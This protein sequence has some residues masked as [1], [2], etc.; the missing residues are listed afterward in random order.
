MSGKK[1]ITIYDIASELKVSPSTVS[2]AL[3]DHFSIGKELTETIKK[4][5]HK[6]GYQ[7]NHIAA[8]LRKNK[9][10]TIGVLIPWINRPFISSLISGVEE[11]ARQNMFNVVISQSH[12]SYESEVA[13]CTTLYNSRI[14]G[15]V[16]SLAMQTKKYDHF[17]Q[18]IE[19]D[20]PVVFVDRVAEELE[21]DRVIIDNYASGFIATE[22]LIQQ[23]CQRIAHFAGAQHRQIYRERQ[24]GYIEALKQYQLPVDEQLIIQ[25]NVLSAEEGHAMTNQ[26]LDLPHPPDGLFSSND[27]AAVS[28]IQIAKKRKVKVP[29]EL[30]IIGFNNDPVSLII[31][32]PLSTIGHPAVDLGRIAAKQVLK[33]RE[34]DVVS[35]ETITL[36]TE[37]IVR[38]SSLK[39]AR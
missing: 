10:N 9:T 11:I 18:F 14:G 13:N 20:I 2:R 28:A 39:K 3:K 38:E 37:L 16:V 22:H 17:N 32:P 8:S 31:D 21:S 33:H 23:G 5:A 34:H 6:Y 1:N 26:L 35:S 30:A 36:K 12:D 4:V 27:T 29:K 19:R 15:L 25:A 24:R 7:P